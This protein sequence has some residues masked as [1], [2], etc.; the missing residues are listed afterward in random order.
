MTR[1][2]LLQLLVQQARRNGFSFRQWFSANTCIP[3]MGATDAIQW[4]SL[5]E[6]ASMLLF[7]RHFAEHFWRS[8]QRVTYL[9]PAQTYQRVAADGSIRT[10]H[11]KAHLRQ[12]SR[13][14]VWEFHLREMAAAAQPLRYI[15]RYLLVDEVVGTTLQ[16]DTES[17]ALDIPQPGTGAAKQQYGT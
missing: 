16:A 7:S 3:W 8:G 2:R 5:G 6:R 17:K 15:R 14:D 10:I 12:S 1:V 13:E 9:V 4:L 11:R